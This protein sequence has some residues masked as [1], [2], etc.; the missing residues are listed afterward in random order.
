MEHPSSH[1]PALRGVNEAT[2]ATLS[3][4]PIAR[5]ERLN[6]STAARIAE[7]AA[8]LAPILVAKGLRVESGSTSPS[9]STTYTRIYLEPLTSTTHDRR[10]SAYN[11]I[12]VW[13][14]Q[15]Q[16]RHGRTFLS[17]QSIQLLCDELLEAVA[18]APTC[19]FLLGQ[20]APTGDEQDG[21]E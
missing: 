13:D 6:A 8:A 10:Q 9:A 2:I 18:A 21:V 17:H 11:V 20:D 3:G 16:S 12:R 4:L 7:T 1:E 5:S 14:W 19:V 15:T